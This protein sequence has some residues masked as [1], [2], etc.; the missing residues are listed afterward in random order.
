MKEEVF[1]TG[2]FNIYDIDL[3]DLPAG[4][5]FLKWNNNNMQQT[6]RIIKQ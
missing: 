1:S 2:S 5:Y 4:L 6:S 3:S